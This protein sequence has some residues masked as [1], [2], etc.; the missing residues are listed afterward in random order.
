MPQHVADTV[1]TTVA[2]DSS[3][4]FAVRVLRRVA[5]A[6]DVAG[7]TLAGEDGRPLPPWEP[8]AHIE[9]V[10]PS[11][12]RRHY[13][14]YGNADDPTYDI[15]VLREENGRGG[16][17][18]L[19]EEVTEGATLRIV[20]PRNRFPFDPTERYVFVAGGIGIT[21]ILPMI[22][23][24][25]RRGIPWTL[26]Y[27]GR[28]RRSMA[29]LD[30]L[31]AMDGGSVQL[32]PQDEQGMIDIE[33]VV[34]EVDDNTLLYACGPEG[35]LAAL[36]GAVLPGRRERLR[37]ERFVAATADDEARAGGPA[38]SE[39]ELV[40]ARTDMTVT[41]PADRT[42]MDIVLEHTPF[43]PFSCGEGYCGSCETPVLDGVPDH[44]DVVLTD[45]ER[46]ANDTMMI[47]VG[48]SLSK[49]LVIDL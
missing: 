7:L 44:R 10:L 19:Y 39:F 35:L 33:A 25:S 5:L 26:V 36:E 32:V 27:G 21:P 22:R 12:L 28:T 15:A 45:E 47:C 49:R 14:L 46:A 13:S 16:S 48:R 41:V 40:L 42:M 4:G 24:A 2:V 18:E 20:G 9:V 17:R 8:G 23:E 11:G 6:D 30:A 31:D 34:A 1:S 3:E 43:A 29:L 37:V 38:D